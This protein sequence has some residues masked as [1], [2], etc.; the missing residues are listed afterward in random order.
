MPPVKIFVSVRDRA[1]CTQE[2]LDG[3]IRSTLG[4]AD[5]Y[6]FD[7]H[8][9]AELAQLLEYYSVLLREG[10]I[11]HLVCNRFDQS[12]TDVYWSKNYAWA[13]FMALVGLLPA[14]QRT[15]LVMI[16]ND[17]FV[18][19]DDWLE[20]S[21]AVL[22]SPEAQK[23][24]VTVVSPYDGP[25]DPFSHPDMFHVLSVDQFSGRTCEVRDAA[26][27]RAWV[28]PW[29]FWTQWRPPTWLQ[30]ERNGKPDRMPTDWYYW[31]NMQRV[32]QRFAVLRPRLLCDPPHPWSSARMENGIGEDAKK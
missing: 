5:I 25:P 8:S 18:R 24:K 12:T 11:A 14:E 23:H 7:N 27:S 26:S 4:K 1:Q 32:G 6:V 22:E 13:Q 21:I 29:Y 30:V 3:L 31:T 9:Q 16:D 19:R 28:A 10:R 20:A 17:V 15:H 2:C